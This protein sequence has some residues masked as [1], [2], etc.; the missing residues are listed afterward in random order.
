[1]LSPLAKN[2]FHKAI[3]KSGVALTAG[4]VKKNTRPLAEKIA[5]VSGCKSTTSAAMVHCLRQKTEEELLETTLKLNLFSLDL[6]G[7]S[8]QSYPFVPTVLDGVVLPKMPEEIL[9]E[10]D[11]NTVPY[12]VG[13]NK[14]EFGWIL[15]TMMNYP[16]SDMKLDPMTATSLLK[17]SSFLLNLPE[18]AIPVAVEKYLRHTDDPDRNKDQLLE[19]IG[20]VI[21]GV[22]SVIVSRG[23]RDAGA[24]TYMYEFQYRPSFSSKMK[25]STVVGDH[26]D[27]IY[28]VFGAPIL[29][30]GTSKEEIN[31]SKMMMKF[32]ANFARNGN[33]NGQGLPHWPEYDQ[34]EGYL[35]IGATTQQAQKL[36]EKEVAFWSELLA[37]KP[38]HAGHTEL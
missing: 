27:E 5:V 23:H 6:H 37:M 12:I 36:K 38:L 32:W 31:L 7:D 20:D 8:R 10:K 16:P 15:P 19:L 11:F 22:P 28:S 21:F 1:M 33:P 34:K 3:S 26:G 13:I 14:Q 4:L 2:L 25:P 35:Q 9:A 18:E 17:K 30:G 29:R 24:R